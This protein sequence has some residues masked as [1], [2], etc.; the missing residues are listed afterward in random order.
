MEPRLTAFLAVARSGRLSEAAKKLNLSVSSVSQQISSL[1]ADFGV[2][3]FERSNRGVALSPAGEALRRHA[4]E[5][6][7]GW[8]RAFREVRRAASGERSVHLAASRPSPRSS[9][10]RCSASSVGASRTSRAHTLTMA[11]SASVLAQVESGQVDF[12]IVEGRLGARSLRATPLWHDELG[13]VVCSRHPWADRREVSLGGASHGRPDP[14]R[15]GFGHPP[16]SSRRALH[17]SGYELGQFRAIMELSSLRAITAMV[18]ATASASA[19]CRA[20]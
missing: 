1:E 6:E 4:E 14:A 2:P 19:S 7:A 9:C 10:R 11:N 3:L 12:G 16:G 20:W 17:Q 18:R 15:G 5:I 13:L 8:R